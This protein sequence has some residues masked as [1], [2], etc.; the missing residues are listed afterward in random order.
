MRVLV[1]GGRD[2]DPMIVQSWLDLM[3][4]KVLPA[5]ITCIVHGGATG[6]DTGAA[7]WARQNKVAALAFPVTADDWRRLGRK[8]GPL[9]NGRMLAEG[10]PDIVVVFP[11]GRGTRDMVAQAQRARVRVLSAMKTRIPIAVE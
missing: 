1:C 2:F 4:P 8:A 7:K 9:R 11:G 6:A 10:K 5:P 3:A